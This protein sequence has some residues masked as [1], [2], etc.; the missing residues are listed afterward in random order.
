MLLKASYTSSSRPQRQ[1]RQKQ[2]QE[3]LEATA[4]TSQGRQG[5]QSLPQEEEEALSLRHV[6]HATADAAG[7]MGGG[8]S[9]SQDAEGGGLG[10]LL[11]ERAGR[12]AIGVC[13]RVCTHTL[14]ALGREALHRGMHAT[15][16]FRQTWQQPTRT[17]QYI[18][19]IDTRIRNHTL[20]QRFASCR[21]GMRHAWK[22]CLS[23]TFGLSESD[24]AVTAVASAD[25]ALALTGADLLHWYKSTCLLVQKYKY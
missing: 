7:G 17:Y 13:T 8:V 15:A 16:V 6:R 9:R 25:A 1:Q 2:E 18:Q 21:A 19:A 20:L 3:V 10:E 5:I 12:D 23:R 4:T 11:F 22:G 14:R 24:A